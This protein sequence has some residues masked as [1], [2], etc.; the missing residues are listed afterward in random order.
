MVRNVYRT[1]ELGQGFDGYLSYHEAYFSVLDASLMVL[2]PAVFNFYW[3]P[4][5]LT[6]SLKYEQ[7]QMKGILISESTQT[8]QLPTSVHDDPS[9]AAGSERL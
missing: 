6:G 5:Y 4:K 1:V 9:I 3:P 8:M 7:I 2:A